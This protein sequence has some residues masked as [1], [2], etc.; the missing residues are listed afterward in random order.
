MAVVGT[1]SLSLGKLAAN[2]L[3]RQ[4]GIER[5]AV[6]A[7][8]AYAGDLCPGR[9]FPRGWRVHR[10]RL[11]FVEQIQLPTVD[12]ILNQLTGGCVRHPETLS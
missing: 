11:G 8:C 7:F 3:A 5:F 2:D 4:V 10:E 6:A 12:C 1:E 9:I